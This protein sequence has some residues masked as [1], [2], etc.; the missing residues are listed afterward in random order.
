[1]VVGFALWACD[2]YE[3]NN[4]EYSGKTTVTLEASTLYTLTFSWTSVDEATSYEYALVEGNI[5]ISKDSAIQTGTTTELAHTF[6][7]LTPGTSYTAWI[8]VIEG[9]NKVSRSFYQ[10]ASTTPIVAL[11]TPA[12]YAS[13][14]D[15]YNPITIRWSPVSGAEAYAYS[16]TI[17]GE[18]V[19]DTITDCA[20]SI[21]AKN[22]S[23]GRYQFTVTALTTKEGYGNSAKGVCY[24]TIG[25]SHP[26]S[27]YDFEGTYTNYCYGSIVQNNAWNENFSATY[28][29]TITA[30][31]GTTILI[32]NVYLK[33][34]L[35]GTIDSDA[36][37]ITFQP[38]KWGSY[39]FA[40]DNTDDDGYAHTLEP[41]TA[42]FDETFYITTNCY[43]R[44]YD[45]YNTGA[46]YAYSYLYNTFT[47]IV[48]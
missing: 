10:T 22:Y 15:G 16:Y 25:E 42:T 19:K 5:S 17:E 28:T 32:T 48:E 18:T 30:V 40:A 47:R 12:P 45:Y 43:I 38:V 20:V 14:D 35:T 6:T 44:G 23:A 39:Y 31:D 27:A 37:T 11:D 34:S 4:F 33:Y 3:R 9:G 36:M 24:F 13:E 26:I 41:V 8:K 21:V 29:S 46:Y 1:M 2:D 7:G